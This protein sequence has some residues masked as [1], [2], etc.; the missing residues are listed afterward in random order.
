M[1]GLQIIFRHKTVFEDYLKG[2]MFCATL[3]GKPWPR[4][5]ETFW[6]LLDK[7]VIQY[8][9]CS[10]NTFSLLHNGLFLLRIPMPFTRMRT[11]SH[12]KPRFFGK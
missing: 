8:K 1:Q 7:E 12:E 5:M 4:A 6:S 9:G 2:L 10:K 3:C 11:S